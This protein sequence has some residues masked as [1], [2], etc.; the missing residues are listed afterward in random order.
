MKS[1]ASLGSKIERY[2]TQTLWGLFMMLTMWQGTL[3]GVDTALAA[4]AIAVN[5]SSEISNSKANIIKQVANQLDREPDRIDSA[6]KN[7]KDPANALLDTAETGVK[8]NAD[9]AEKPIDD[10]P[11]IVKKTSE[12]NSQQAGKFS[13]NL[14][15]KIKNI[16]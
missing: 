15:K 8:I 9:K 14:T 5:S 13:K 11:E 2:L 6:T 1:S 3:F 4:P 12:R 16:P 7:R 10:S